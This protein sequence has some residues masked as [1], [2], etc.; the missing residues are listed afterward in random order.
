[1]TLILEQLQFLRP[2]W[3]DLVEI[4][5]VAFLLY[6]L[7][8]VL[9]RTRAM[10]IMLGVVALALL[11]GASRLLDLILIRTMLEAAFQYGAIAVLVVFQPELRSALARLGR[12]RMMRAFQRMEGSRVTEEIVEAV[13]RL[14]HAR[15]GAIIAIEQEIGLDEYAETGSPVDARVSAEML[16]TI[17]T[18]YSPLHDGAVLVVG[19]QIR[20]AGAILPLTQSTVKDR[21]LGTRHRA[22]LGLSEETDAIVIVV[23]EETSQVSLAVGGRLDRDVGMERLRE[24]LV[25]AAPASESPL[26]SPKSVLSPS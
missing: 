1:M 20:T 13:E 4:L 12:S 21:S 10:Q 25:G 16:T 17:F 23:S 11:Y 24:T 2:G 22:A 19:D 8:L 14:S 3:T 5:I 26:V 18:P 9:Q 7:L 15:H 6:R